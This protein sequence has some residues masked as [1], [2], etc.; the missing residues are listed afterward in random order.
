M[1]FTSPVYGEYGNTVKGQDYEMFR[2]KTHAVIRFQGYISS[3]TTGNQFLKRNNGAQALYIPTETQG[4][5]TL[6]GVCVD[7]TNEVP[8]N[9]Y[10]AAGGVFENDGGTTSCTLSATAIDTDVLISLNANDTLDCLEV[11]VLETTVGSARAVFV[12]VDLELNWLNT[13]Y[14][15]LLQ[16]NKFP[17]AGTAT[18]SVAE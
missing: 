17:T 6:S 16:P 9:V 10:L 13:A 2:S 14:K 5:V 1:S 7:I 15:G 12:A 18:V 8:Y 11:G 4:S 3:I